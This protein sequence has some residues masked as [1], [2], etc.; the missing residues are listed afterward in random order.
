MVLIG[1]F[2]CGDPLSDLKIGGSLLTSHAKEV[3]S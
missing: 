1:G 3:V 2:N